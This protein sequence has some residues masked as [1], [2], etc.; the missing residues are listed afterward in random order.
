[1]LRNSLFED[2]SLEKSFLLGFWGQ[3]FLVPLCDMGTLG[4]CVS[5]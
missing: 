4:V 5:V 1:M 2:G 3:W